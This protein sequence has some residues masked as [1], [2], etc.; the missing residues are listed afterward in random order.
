MADRL[1]GKYSDNVCPSAT[2]SLTVGA[3]N[4]SYP[5]TNLQDL[6]PNTPFKATGTSATIR[7]TFGAG[8]AL[9]AVGLVWHN[10]YGLT[11]TVTNNAAMASQS[12]VVPAV[13]DD[14]LPVNPWLDL[15]TVTTSA[16]QWNFEITGAAANIAIGEL[17]L[18]ET[19]R[20]MPIRWGV[21]V[22]ERHPAIVHRTDYHVPLIYGMGVRYRVLTGDITRASELAALKAL[23]RDARGTRYPWW[24]VLDSDVNDAMFVHFDDA[25][26]WAHQREYNQSPSSVTIEEV[27]PG[28]AL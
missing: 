19:V 5:L 13:S 23:H 7:A 16:T 17:I 4:A 11:I 15:R 24:F 12:L 20:T 27:C 8:K 25:S 22:V 21:E 26:E 10:L 2:L 28:L 6:K 18:I 9:Q 1:Y 14:G 3:A